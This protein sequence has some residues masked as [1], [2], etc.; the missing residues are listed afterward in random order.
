MKRVV[1]YFE[2]NWAFGTVHYELCKY[3]WDYGFNC[4]VLPWNKSYTRQEM[5]E[6][7]DTTDIFVTTPH[8]WRFLGYDYCTVKPEQCVIISH[9]KLD[10]T[11]LIHFHGYEDFYRFKKYGAVSQWLVDLSKEL[12]ITRPAELTP[13]GVNCNTFYSK[14][15]ERLEIVGYTGSFHSREEFN[16]EMINSSLAQPKYHKRG[17]LVKEAAEQCGLGFRI[18]QHYHNSF[19]TMPGF[20]KNVDAIV[21]ASTEEGA[22]LPVMEGGA[23]GKL[24]ISTPV[25]HW[26]TKI[27]EAGGHAVPVGEREFLDKT[28][29]LLS[30][31]KSNPDKY[32]ARCLEIQNHAQSYD[33]RHVIE[34]WVSIL[35]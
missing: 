14:P 6:L 23:A 18:A 21:A 28:V 29:E 33:W 2:P 22:G 12:G 34:K 24:I 4:Q 15:S 30:Y 8:G 9:A 32:K 3:L 31:Y 20:Y 26:D 27:T 11:E 19:I 16:Q 13:V 1:F 10:M 7:N 35:S 17:W 5:E 25:G